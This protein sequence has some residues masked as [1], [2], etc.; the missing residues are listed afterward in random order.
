M[1]VKNRN[2][3]L[4]IRTVACRKG[5]TAKDGGAADG[6]TIQTFRYRPYV[7][8]RIDCNNPQSVRRDSLST[9]LVGGCY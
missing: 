9:M 5:P 7:P 2:K 4:K 6:R 1:S 3:R 8:N